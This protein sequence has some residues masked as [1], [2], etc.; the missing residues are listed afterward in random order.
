MAKT[1]P[2]EVTTAQQP[3]VFT[4]RHFIGRSP[5]AKVPKMQSPCP[6]CNQL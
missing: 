1:Q 4:H 3:P 6:K 5:F 2:K